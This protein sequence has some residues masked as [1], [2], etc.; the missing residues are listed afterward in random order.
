MKCSNPRGVEEGLS[1]KS[2]DRR[3]VMA[4]TPD[5]KIGKIEFNEQHVTPFTDHV[6]AIGTTSA[7]SGG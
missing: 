4:L 1:C 5:T 7:E 3:R 2:L 6:V